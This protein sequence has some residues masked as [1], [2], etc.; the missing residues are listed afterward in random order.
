MARRQVDDRAHALVLEHLHPCCDQLNVPPRR[1]PRAGV[2]LQEAS[3][4]ERLEVGPQQS[5][6][7]PVLF[8]GHEE[9]SFF[10]RWTKVPNTCVSSSV[11]KLRSALSAGGAATGSSVGPPPRC[12]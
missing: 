2:E 7:G 10:K 3:L 8:G 4:G 1:K 5:L 9:P 12:L 6:I 11:P